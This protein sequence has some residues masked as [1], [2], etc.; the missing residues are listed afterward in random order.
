M[1]KIMNK[2][3]FTLAELLVVVAIIA[4]LVA[5]SIPIFT[6]QLEKSREATDIANM[7]AA[8]AEAVTAYL[9]G[10]TESTFS[11]TAGHSFAAYYDGNK[12]KLFTTAPSTVT[13]GRGTS[14]VGATTN[15]ELGYEP[16]TPYTDKK[17]KVS[18]NNKGEIT[19]F[20]E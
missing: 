2:K 6:S 7:R 18:V 10:S 14:T 5:V 13:M 11:V 19:N 3:G 12:G 20:W 16:G 1:K 4:I 8:K 17:L 15:T 9:T